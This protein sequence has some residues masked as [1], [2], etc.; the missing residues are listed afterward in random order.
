MLDIGG[1][2]MIATARTTLTKFASSTLGYMFN[3]MHDLKQ[4]KGRVFI[5]RDGEPFTHVISYLRSGK[6]PVFNTKHEELR[7]IEEM[8][9]WQIPLNV[10]NGS[11]FSNEQEFDSEWCASTLE[12]T[13]DHK[14]VTKDSPSH[15][16]V[17]CKIPFDETNT[18]VD[19]KIT[20]DVPSRTKSHLFVGVV[21]REKYKKEYLVSTF[22]KDSPSSYYWDIWSTKL[23]ENNHE[24]IQTSC[25]FG[26]QCED[27]ETIIGKLPSVSHYNTF[28]Y[29]VSRSEQD[30]LILQER[31][32]H[33]KSLQKR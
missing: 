8:D 31:L 15:G 9:F 16:I 13:A 24:G 19:F 4:H 14:T 2:H 1:T 25:G 17:F 23:I 29:A 26:C 3:G 5:D 18:Y 7:F 28:R 6:V 11:D 32:Y 12:L 10:A 33:W 22:W 20:I 27:N 30:N 21:D